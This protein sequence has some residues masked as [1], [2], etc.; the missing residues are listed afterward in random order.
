M[1]APCLSP[2]DVWKGVSLCLTGDD[3]FS[4]SLLSVLPS[5]NHREF[6]RILARVKQPDCV[7]EM[8]HRSEIVHTLEVCT[9]STRGAGEDHPM[10]PR[11]L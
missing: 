8:W 4:P 2:C 3:Q 5:R 9:F 10:E 11:A 1:G 7:N 6:W